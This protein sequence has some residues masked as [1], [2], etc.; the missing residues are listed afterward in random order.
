ME[1][2]REFA[3]RKT[4]CLQQKSTIDNNKS[5]FL[6]LEDMAVMLC[7][8][9]HFLSPVALTT[10]SLEADHMAK[11]SVCDNRRESMLVSYTSEPILAFWFHEAM[12]STRTA[13]GLCPLLK[14]IRTALV[15][16]VVYTGS[17]VP[18]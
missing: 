4:F 3:R 12:E 8:L 14:S 17:G 6:Y 9:C 2:V 16:G 18:L 7:R 1:E 11:V 5:H 10:S 13:Q 15:Q